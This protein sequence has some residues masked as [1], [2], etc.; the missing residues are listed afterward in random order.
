MNCYTE[1]AHL[2]ALLA[3]HYP[4]RGY[5]DSEGDPGFDHVI[6]LWIPD[7]TDNG[8][9]L[10]WH[11]ADADLDLFHHVPMKESVYDGHSTDDKY[12]H[13][14]EWFVPSLR[15]HRLARQRGCQLRRATLCRVPL[16]HPVSALRVEET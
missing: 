5:V 16:H 4:C 2:L 6:A 14:R 10:C 8:R 15:G 9:W 3:T 12:D 7:Q 13:I 1:R 11:I